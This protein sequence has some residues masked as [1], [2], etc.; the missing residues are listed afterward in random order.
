MNPEGNGIKWQV[1]NHESRL[2]KLEEHNY[3]VLQNKV[4]N[5]EARMDSVVRAL[6]S[7][8]GALAVATVTFVLAIAT[9]Q[10]G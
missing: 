10:L 4:E 8:A 9:G 7:V 2:Q 3:A 1:S 5:V 6:W